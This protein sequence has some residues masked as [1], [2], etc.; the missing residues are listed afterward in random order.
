MEGRDF[1]LVKGAVVR[2][3]NVHLVSM[4]ISRAGSS[5]RRCFYGTKPPVRH[6]WRL[7]NYVE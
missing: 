7:G 5:G 1:I 4:L 3:M 6:C 2:G